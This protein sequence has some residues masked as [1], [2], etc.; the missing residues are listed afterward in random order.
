MQT[1]V[2][3]NCSLVFHGNTSSVHCFDIVLSLASFRPWQAA[4]LPARMWR[5]QIPAA[6]SLICHHYCA[7]TISSTDSWNFVCRHEGVRHHVVGCGRQC[8]TASSDLTNTR[9]WEKIRSACSTS[10]NRSSSFFL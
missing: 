8:Q 9:R 4:A 3:T 7:A 6:R 2:V 10:A 5:M 1:P